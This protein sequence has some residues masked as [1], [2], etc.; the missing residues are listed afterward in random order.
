MSMF[1][2]SNVETSF[3]TL[4]AS[5][6]PIE[7]KQVR[8]EFGNW[9]RERRE[10]LKLSQGG[11]ADKVGVDRQTIYRLEA[12]QTG[13]KRETVIAIATALNLSVDEALIKSG[14]VTTAYDPSNAG[15]LKGLDRLSPENQIAVK[16]AMQALIDSL[17]EKDEDFDYVDDDFDESKELKTR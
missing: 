5:M 13:T 8:R 7:T 16:R 10:A 6:Q 2:S 11:V 17:A 3:V 15:D 1:A 14:L 9:I 4:V 12:G